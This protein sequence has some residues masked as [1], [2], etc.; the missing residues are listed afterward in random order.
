MAPT[1]VCDD[2]ISTGQS[3]DVFLKVALLMLPQVMLLVVP[4]AAF[5]ATLYSINQLFL[6]AEFIIFM[7]VGKSNI[8]I[9]KAILIFGFSIAGFMYFLSLFLVP[10]SQHNLKVTIFEMHQSITGQL[11]K[12]GRFFHPTD[13]VSLYIRDSNKEGEMRGIFITDNSAKVEAPALVMHKSP[14]FKISL[15]L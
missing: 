5:S 11:I 2:I 10:L 7:S 8:S 6:D 12:A 14:C 15:R 13:G 1:V 4:L 9:S 3:A